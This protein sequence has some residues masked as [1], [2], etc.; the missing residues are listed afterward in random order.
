MNAQVLMGKYD[1]L[2][3][4]LIR[5]LETTAKRIDERTRLL[6]NSPDTLQMLEL[7]YYHTFKSG[8]LALEK[9]GILVF[10]LKSNGK[11]DLSHCRY[12]ELGVQ[13]AEELQQEVEIQYDSLISNQYLR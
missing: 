12:T 8:L 13:V 2:S 9:Q 7:N 6:D 10:D 4:V 1:T 11:K 3:L 5:W